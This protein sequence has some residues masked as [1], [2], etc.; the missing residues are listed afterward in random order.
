MSEKLKCFIMAV[1]GLT[2]ICIGVDL[3]V[4]KLAH[5]PSLFTLVFNGAINALIFIVGTRILFDKRWK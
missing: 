5:G 1:V 3:L 2:L 4:I